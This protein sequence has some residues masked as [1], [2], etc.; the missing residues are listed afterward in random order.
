M[1][2]ADFSPK[3]LPETDKRTLNCKLLD[4]RIKFDK[5]KLRKSFSGIFCQLVDVPSMCTMF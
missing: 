1:I 2:D 3:A 5:R 4:L